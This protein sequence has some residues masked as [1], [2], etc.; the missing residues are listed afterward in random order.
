[1]KKILLVNPPSSYDKSAIAMPLNLMIL[2]S[3]GNDYNQK[4]DI[5]DL[6]FIV[7]KDNTIDYLS[8]LFNTILEK[9][10]NVIGITTNCLNYPIVI[11]LVEKIK[12]FNKKLIVFL[13]GPQAGLCA[14]ETMIS[15][16]NIDFIIIGEGENTFRELLE[17]DF[18]GLE[19]ISGL[20]IRSEGNKVLLT[21]KR[22]LIFNLDD[23]PYPNYQGIDI[24]EYLK[25][26]EKNQIPVVPIE[27]GR[28]CPYNCTFCC[29]S[30]FWERKYRT[31]SVSRVLN[32]IENYIK[33]GAKKFTFIHDNLAVNHQYIKEL[34]IELSKYK[35][36]SWN[37]SSRVDNLNQNIIKYLSKGGCKGIFLGIETGSKR[38]QKDIN[39]N[40][41]I[42]S[43]FEIIKECK[44]NGIN[45][46]CSFI[47]GFPNET[48]EE[49]NETLELAL[50]CKIEGADIE[51]QILSPLYKT[52]I[53]NKYEDKIYLNNNLYDKY[54]IFLE[55]NHAM[56][57]I[58]TS[59]KLYSFFYTLDNENL[60]NN[61]LWFSLFFLRIVINNLPEKLLKILKNMKINLI[62]LCKEYYTKNTLKSKNLSE[63]EVQ[64]ELIYSLYKLVVGEL[65]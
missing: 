46:T 4:I 65:K 36:L 19:K 42:S 62:D 38:L 39:K 25:E 44:N 63:K 30:L 21:E 33:L 17:N 8:F 41:D 3:I 13:G 48:L 50:K 5:L 61:F 45:T 15:Y 51:I 49:L 22:K 54:N 20:C 28:G 57:K 35:N 6:D 32:E 60:D 34:S 58:K 31:K 29:T 11:L 7:K 52:K 53:Y 23:T 2:S 1:M 40:L 55:R 18:T 59:K 16:K 24:F 14:E 47:L 64:F 27:V 12:D 9:N 43:V 37:I 10:I 26:I 56:T